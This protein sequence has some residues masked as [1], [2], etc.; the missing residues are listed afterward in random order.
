MHAFIKVLRKRQSG[1]GEII[2]WLD[3]KIERMGVGDRRMDGIIR[4]M[5]GKG[6][7]G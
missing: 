1:Y 6:M 4:D 3:A 5:A 2:A 7:G